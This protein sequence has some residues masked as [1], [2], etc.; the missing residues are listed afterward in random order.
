MHLQSRLRR[1]ISARRI[2][3]LLALIVFAGPLAALPPAQA[4]RFWGD[5]DKPAEQQQSAPDVAAPAKP[6]I[7]AGLPNF[8]DLAEALRPAVVNI[9]TTAPVEVPHMQMPGPGGPRQFGPGGPG[10]QGGPGGPGQGDPY[11]E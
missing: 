10:G 6:P 11:H 3:L 9:S 7:V 4:I 8:A 2:G 5:E 1:P